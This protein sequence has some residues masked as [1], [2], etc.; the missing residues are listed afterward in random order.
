MDGY[1]NAASILCALRNFC[2]SE[3]EME[4]LERSFLS[5]II[6]CLLKR[7]VFSLSKI[8]YCVSVQFS[9]E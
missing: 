5:E 8:S 1:R 6:F 2:W 3:L 4:T 9:R 7:K